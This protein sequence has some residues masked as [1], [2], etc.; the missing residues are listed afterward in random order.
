MG[1][2]LRCLRP[3]VCRC[4]R[5]AYRVV[6]NRSLRC[7]QTARCYSTEGDSKIPQDDTQIDG[8][9]GSQSPKPRIRVTRGDREEPYFPPYP[10]IKPQKGV[11]DYQTFRERFQSLGK[12]DS[13]SDEV[14]VRGRLR[15]MSPLVSHWLILSRQNMVISDSWLQTCV[16]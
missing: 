4:I 8:A 1:N 14:T 12:G 3:C 6:S 16:H 13:H 10:R 9:D 15:H 5:P 2:P 7:Y 11:I